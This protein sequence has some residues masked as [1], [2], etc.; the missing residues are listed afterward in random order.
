MWLF[1]FK[2]DRVC[3]IDK[4]ILEEWK[5]YYKLGKFGA[6]ADEQL[7]AN[8]GAH[9]DQLNQEKSAVGRHRCRF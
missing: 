6:A 7:R 8:L 5:E 9:I 1:H 2:Q 4:L 3:E